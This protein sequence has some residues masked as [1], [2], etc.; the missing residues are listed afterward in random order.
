VEKNSVRTRLA[1]RQSAATKPRWAAP[2]AML[3]TAATRA[4][5]A[6][7]W[8]NILG[9]AAMTSVSPVLPSLSVVSNMKPVS[10]LSSMKL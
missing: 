5:F 7:A 10:R 8:Y 1:L 3:R 9:R 6:G 2:R 4:S